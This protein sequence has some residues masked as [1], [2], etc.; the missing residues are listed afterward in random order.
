MDVE[1][2]WT[3][4]VHGAQDDIIHAGMALLVTRSVPGSKLILYQ[5]HSHS[6]GG[7]AL[8]RLVA[9]VL[10][11]VREAHASETHLPR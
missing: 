9:Q 4:G 10:V 8:E 2:D 11:F 5:D 7:E 6:L 1:V 3:R